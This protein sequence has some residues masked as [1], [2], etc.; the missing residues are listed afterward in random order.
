MSYMKHV[1][2]RI[3]PERNQCESLRAFWLSFTEQC[4]SYRHDKTA[5]DHTLD[6]NKTNKKR[7]RFPLASQGLKKCNSTLEILRGSPDVNKRTHN[8]AHLH[9][10][11]RSALVAPEPGH[12][13][14][15][16][17]PEFL[18]GYYYSTSIN[19]QCPSNGFELD[20]LRDMLPIPHIA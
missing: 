18:V 6:E 7:I 8:R 10:L 1:V 16:I 4:I 20:L 3:A 17:D 9:T 2:L 11:C 15:W 12:S 13:W 19:L 5:T 14:E